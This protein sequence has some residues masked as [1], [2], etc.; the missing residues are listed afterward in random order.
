MHPAIGSEVPSKT[1]TA[2]SQHK[3]TR[4]TQMQQPRVDS[5]VQPLTFSL[6]RL[7]NR[8]ADHSAERTAGDLR[9]PD[10]MKQH[11]NSQ[12]VNPND[13]ALPHPQFRTSD[14]AFT[15]VELL[16]VIAII[17][18]LIGLL[19]PALSSAR[20][21]ARKTKC[22]ASHKGLIAASLMY[23]DDS[24]EQL[25]H[26]NWGPVSTGWL[27]VGNPNTVVDDG[28]GPSTGLIWP[29]VGGEPDSLNLKLAD[30]YRCASHKGPYRG[31]GRLSSYQMNGAVLGY[32]RA[33]WSFRISMFMPFATVF[34]ESDE[35][36]ISDANWNDG[37]SFPTEDIARNHAGGRG[38]TLALIDGSAY[39]MTT[40]EFEREIERFPG[41]LWSAPDT[42]DGR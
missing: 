25:P 41:K 26:P 40:P 18:L 1:H 3:A 14:S 15:L 12:A 6:S 30:V 31:T 35:D 34:W 24:R 10:P 33:R 21:S 11:M 22:L 37:A 2:R 16:V 28:R 5:A 17:A 8:T 27:Y 32:G 4:S 19:L 42:R 29:Y 13:R 9:H 38:S 20:D 36:G 7:P 23:A 39:W